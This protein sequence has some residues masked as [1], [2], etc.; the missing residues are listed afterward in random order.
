MPRKDVIA[1]Q[2]QRRVRDVKFFPEL[3]KPNRRASRSA[4]AW[5]EVTMDVRDISRQLPRTAVIGEVAPQPRRISSTGFSSRAVK[6][7]G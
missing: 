3:N 1:E 7:P 4:S 6:S 5:V 2:L